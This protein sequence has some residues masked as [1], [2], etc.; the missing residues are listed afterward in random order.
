MAEQDTSWIQEGALIIEHFNSHAQQ[1]VRLWRIDKV[2]PKTFVVQGTRVHK[3]KMETQPGGT[4]GPVHR[5]LNPKSEEAKPLLRIRE[6]QRARNRVNNAISDWQKME[7]HGASETDGY[8][9]QAKML[10]DLL[11]DYIKVEKGE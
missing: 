5:Y 8:A 1:H 3:E 2:S 7:R 4:W 9:A 6:V 11:L 10:S